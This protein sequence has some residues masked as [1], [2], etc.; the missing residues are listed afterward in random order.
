MTALAAVVGIGE[1]PSGR[2]PERTAI[3]AALA[4]SNQAIKQSGLERSEIDVVM[5]TGALYSSEWSTSLAVSRLA[6]DLGLLGTAHSNTSV[7]GGGSS[8][9]LQLQLA[10][11][12]IKSGLAKS[13]L[14]IHSDRLGSGVDHLAGIDLFATAGMSSEWEIPLGINF[15]AVAGLITTR[16]KHETGATDE[17]L[18]AVCVSMRKWAELNENAM[19]RKPLTVEEVMS[20]KMLSTPLRA[21]MSNMLADGASAFIVVAPERGP[22]LVERPVYLLGAGGRVSHY[23]IAAERDLAR[24]GYAAAA[25]DAFGMAGLSPG[26]MQLA[27]IYDSYPVFVLIALEELGL[28]ERGSA[29]Q[30]VAEGNTWP[31]GTLPT[32]TN[33]GMLSQGHTGAGG[34]FAILVETIR[35]L[36]GLAGDRQVPGARFAVETAT[37][38]NYMD[39]HVSVLGTAAP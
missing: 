9:T 25:S 36:M 31:G 35:Q 29:G 23:T 7:F 3:E 5:P 38:G 16:Y 11:G 37:G 30:F 33:G 14:C 28:V 27:Q 15:S 8:A 17:Q 2:F 39:A 18:A 6:E 12:L 24:F 4:A 32:T 1:V 20:S 21:K 26:D 34:G 19:Y 13:V 10:A 22:D